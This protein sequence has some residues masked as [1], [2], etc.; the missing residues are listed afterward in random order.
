MTAFSTALGVS[1]LEVGKIQFDRFWHLRENARN[2]WPVREIDMDKIKNPGPCCPQ[3]LNQGGH[4]IFQ[5]V[6]A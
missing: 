2:S 1:N 5:T 4:G 3:E 6:L